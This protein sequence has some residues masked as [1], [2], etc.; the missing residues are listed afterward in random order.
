MKNWN[1]KPYY[2]FDYMLKERFSEKI[3]KTALNGGMT[4]PNRDGTLGTR[5]CI[6][7][8]QGGSGD[9]AGDRRDSITLQIDKQAAKLSQKRKASAFIAYFQAYTN[10]YAPAEYLKKIYTEAI[11]HPLVAAVS[12]G[13][14]PDCLGPEV[15]DLLEELNR[16]KP[17]WVELG[18]QTIHEQ[19]AE[20]IRRGYPLSCFEDAVKALHQ[21]NLEVI[22]HTIL[23]LPGESRKDILETMEYLNRQK[24]QGIKL[25]LLHVLK[26][27]DLAQDYLDGKFSVYSMEEYLDTVID[28]LE[29]LSP[30]IVIHRLTGDGPKDLLIAPLW[31]SKKRTVLNALHHECKMRGAYQGRLYKED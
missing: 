26:G 15:L 3:Y 19:T 17:V 1:G 11:R 31:S 4:C 20:Y 7:C 23:G 14:R 18:L 27:T 9:F 2:S 16:I 10:T 6:F 30:D 13:T 5:G 12:I 21:R 25:Q 24:I 28:C 29:H 22:V 8:S